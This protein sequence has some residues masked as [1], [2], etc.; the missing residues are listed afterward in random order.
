MTSTPTPH[1]ASEALGLWEPKR[2]LTLDAARRHSARIKIIRRVLIVISV[3]A[4]ICV[5]WNFS[6]RS[7][8]IIQEI[9]P[10]ESAR[11]G[12]PRF[13][14]RTSDGLPYKLT[15]AQAVRLN[16]AA[17]D[18]ELVDP[19]L[20]FFRVAGAET[21]FVLAK[22]GR[23]NDVSQ[24]LDLRQDVDLKTDDGNHCVTSHARIFTIENRLEGSE[25][26]KCNGNF[27]IITGETYEILDGYKT[28]IF[29][30]GMTAELI[31]ETAEDTAED[32]EFGG[33]GIINVTAQDATY[34]NGTTV[35]TG[36]VIVT[37]DDSVIK[38]DKMTIY[39]QEEADARTALKLGEISRIVAD[40]NFS[41]NA[42]QNTVT[43]DRGVYK[44]S[45][46]Q[47]D[48]FGNVS[49]KQASGNFVES[50]CLFYDLESKSAR[51]NNTLNNASCKGRINI[52]I[53]PRGD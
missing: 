18:I 12:N 22:T 35:L 29:K 1:S 30:N 46:K 10:T 25:F 43:G 26:I 45:N 38:A 19:E 51:F 40:G 15:A 20:E 47:I 21:S 34:R 9:N 41:Y 39:R 14:G 2:T 13:S 50:D 48:V 27:G 16:N 28:F 52:T 37:Q 36:N 31:N 24:I 49:L 23:Y 11:M 6:K 33:A 4:A 5:V 44:R 32:I 7:T 8:V 17:N 3:I 42:P 53:Q